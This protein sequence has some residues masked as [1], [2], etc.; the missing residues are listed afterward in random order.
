MIEGAC[1]CGRVTWTLKRDP[2]WLCACNCSYCRRAGGLW[3]HAPIADVSLDYDP[4]AVVRYS[5]GDRT[6]AFVSCANCGCTTHY[7]STDPEQW[8][9]MAVNCAMGAPEHIRHLRVRHFDG[10]DSWAYLD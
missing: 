7:E 3:G 9:R 6:L 4:A 2:E 1:H 10:A 5:H 8:P